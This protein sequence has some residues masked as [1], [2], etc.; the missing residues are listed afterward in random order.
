MTA[1][2]KEIA[3]LIVITTFIASVGV[4]SEAMRLVM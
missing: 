2:V 4:V 1:F 3:A